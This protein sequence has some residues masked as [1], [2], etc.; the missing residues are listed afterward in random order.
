MR[1]GCRVG[2]QAVGVRMWVR[3]RSG[4]TRHYWQPQWEA[5]SCL[6]F[7]NWWRQLIASRLL[8][9]WDKLNN[10][11]RTSQFNRVHFID[12]SFKR[13]IPGTFWERRSYFPFSSLENIKTK[14]VK[15]RWC[16]MLHAVNIPNLES[17]STPEVKQNDHLVQIYG[18][19]TF[20]RVKQMWLFR[21]HN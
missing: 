17:K 9:Q 8:A 15:P 21:L 18:W 1:N 5:S 16:A 19:I 6:C 13:H 14:G 3:T 10:V 4:R 2:G 12:T 7:S 11:P 20:N